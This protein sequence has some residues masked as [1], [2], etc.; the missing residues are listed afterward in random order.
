MSLSRIA[1]RQQDSMIFL[2]AK[3]M[4]EKVAAFSKF[5]DAAAGEL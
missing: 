3:K 2:A 1:Y 5:D 4:F